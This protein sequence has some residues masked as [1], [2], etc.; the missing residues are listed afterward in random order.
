[1]PFFSL[2]IEAP[3]RQ[4]IAV[5]AESREVAVAKFGAKLGKRLSLADQDDEPPYLMNE[6]PPGP[7]PHWMRF[8]IPVWELPPD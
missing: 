8:D 6:T 5:S 7:G 1:M 4:A 3:G 2:L